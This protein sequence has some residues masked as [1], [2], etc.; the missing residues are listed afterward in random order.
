MALTI[1]E[2]RAIIAY[3]IQ[4]SDAAMLEA[5]DNAV[6]KHWSLVANRLY[7]AVFHMASA[8]MV[9]KGFTTKSHAGLIC[10]LGQ[11]FVVRGLLAK[12]DVRLASRL[13]NMRQAGDYDDMFD[14]GEEDVAPLFPKTEVLLQ[15]MKE[16]VSLHK[17]I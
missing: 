8:L 4:K 12:E 10:L 7:Y 13:L 16:L 9:D 2:K 14:W 5:R 11:E 17:D 3:R 15:K 6:L 1:D